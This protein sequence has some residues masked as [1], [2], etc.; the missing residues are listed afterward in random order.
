MKTKLKRVLL[1]I[2]VMAVVLLFLTALLMFPDE[3][4]LVF[5]YTMLGIVLVGLGFCAWYWTEDVFN[6]YKS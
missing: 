2:A 1:T 4:A 3:T 5:A 6:D